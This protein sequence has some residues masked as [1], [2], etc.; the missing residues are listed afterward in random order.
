MIQMSNNGGNANQSGAYINDSDRKTPEHDAICQFLVESWRSVA[1]TL[2]V[3]CDKTH[4]LVLVPVPPLLPCEK[5]K[6]C[7]Y[8]PTTGGRRCDFTQYHRDCEECSACLFRMETEKTRDYS[9][10]CGVVFRAGEKFL[11]HYGRFCEVVEGDVGCPKNPGRAITEVPLANTDRNG[12]T[13]MNGYVDV[14]IYASDKIGIEVK[15]K[16]CS[17]SEVIRQ[18]EFYRHND[19]TNNQRIGVAHWVYVSPYPLLVGDEETLTAHNI[20][21]IQVG[22]AFKK[23][24]A[25]RQ[26]ASASKVL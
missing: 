8:C 26:I 5:F 3:V 9:C 10:S 11:K 22:P 23:W 21:F 6:K 1:D 4:S 17:T 12:R 16:P 2:G 20:S 14:V 7:E 13:W 15:S 18:I 19:R 24:K 25:S